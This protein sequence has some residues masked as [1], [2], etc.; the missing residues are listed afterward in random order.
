MNKL[1]GRY[2]RLALCAVFVASF[3][4]ASGAG[5]KWCWVSDR[6]LF[7]IIIDAGVAPCRSWLHTTS[8]SSAWRSCWLLRLPAAPGSSG[9]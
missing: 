6:K 1:L 3:V 5:R 4:L 9:A 2:P 8:I 7:L